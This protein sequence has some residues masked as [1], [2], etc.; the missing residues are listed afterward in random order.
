[1]PTTPSKLPF[2]L[3]ILA[4]VLTLVSLCAGWFVPY[5]SLLCPLIAIVLAVFG[6]KSQRKAV[7]IVALV[8]SIVSFCILGG[9]GWFFWSA[10]EYTTAMNELGKSLGSLFQTILQ[11]IKTI[12]RIP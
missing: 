2:W 9:V 1:M 12:L 5:A 11:L 10:P 4:L 3:S 8:L 7:S 6:L